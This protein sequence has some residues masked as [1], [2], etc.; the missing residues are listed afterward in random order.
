MRSVMDGFSHEATAI[1]A[2]RLV[3]YSGEIITCGEVSGSGFHPFH[4][5]IAIGVNNGPRGHPADTGIFI[6]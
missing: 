3:G 2:R 4:V 1:V 5:M 6:P